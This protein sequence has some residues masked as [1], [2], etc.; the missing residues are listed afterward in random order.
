MAVGGPPVQ[1]VAAVAAVGRRRGSVLD[2]LVDGLLEPV[3]VGGPPGSESVVAV[4]VAER[5]AGAVV[6]G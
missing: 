4:A 1:V 3:V 6:G 2:P 5:R